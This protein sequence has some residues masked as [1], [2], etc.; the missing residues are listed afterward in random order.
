MK[1]IW[2][3]VTPQQ[4]RIGRIVGP[5][6]VVDFDAIE[7]EADAVELPMFHEGF[8]NIFG[9]DV[10]LSSVVQVPP[11]HLP[12]VRNVFRFFRLREGD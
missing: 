2:L 1:L 6:G 10:N 11:C 5:Y 8:E 9:D 4:M 12:V 7:V 3:L